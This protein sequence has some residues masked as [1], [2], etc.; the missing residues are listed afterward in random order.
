MHPL[1][2]EKAPKEILE[3]IPA[4]IA[5]YYTQI[6]NPKYPAQRVSFGTSGHRGSATK[7]SFN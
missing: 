5:A 4:L 2:G 3:D 7:K 1:A 6:P